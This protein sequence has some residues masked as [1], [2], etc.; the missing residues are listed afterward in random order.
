MSE[1]VT[2]DRKLIDIFDEA[3]HLYDS[4]EIRQ[5][6]TNSDSFQN[7]IKKCIGLFEDATRLVSL[8]GVFSANESHEEIATSDLRYL[9]LPFFLAVLN[10]K[11]CGSNRK[12]CV[13]VAEIYYK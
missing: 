2:I 11:L 8:C 7:D 10:L 12:H 13:E 1:E 4:F 3:Y 5:D 9:L 6:P